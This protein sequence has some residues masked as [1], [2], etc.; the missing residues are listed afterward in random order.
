M[1]VVFGENCVIGIDNC[2]FW[3]LLVDFKYFKVMIFGKLV[4]MGCKIWDLLGW[5]LLGWLNLVVS[6]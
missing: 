1:I 5:L 3:C 4:I 2:L 6:C